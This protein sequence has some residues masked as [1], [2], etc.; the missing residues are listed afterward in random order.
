[1][2]LSSPHIWG[3]P[4]L[5]D[6][7]H[8]GT[9]V[10]VAFHFEILKKN[11]RI[12]IAKASWYLLYFW[13]TTLTQPCNTPKVY[14]VYRNHVGVLQGSPWFQKYNDIACLYAFLPTNVI[15]KLHINVCPFVCENARKWLSLY[16]R[17]RSKMVVPKCAKIL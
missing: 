2:E 12:H 15:Y 13:N 14:E 4:F 10:S 5:S 9:E 1:M 7:A 17:K 16:V 11:R 8:E 3:Q 6:F